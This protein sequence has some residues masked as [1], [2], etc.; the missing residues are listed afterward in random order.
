MPRIALL[1]LTAAMTVP[2][3]AADALDKFW[4]G[5]QTLCGHAY[6][7]ELITEPGGEDGFAGRALVMHVREC[8]PDRIRIPFVVGEDRS[9]TWVLTRVTVDGDPRLELKHD[10][11]DEDGRDDEIT[12]YGGTTTNLGRATQ[13]L[14]PADPHTREIIEPAH[15]NVWRIEVLPG[16]RFSYH[17]RRLGTER[18]FRVDFDLTEPVDPPGPPWGW[19]V[20]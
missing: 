5:L 1:A 8:T 19:Q 4:S 10:H 6:A 11:R 15:A 7:G 13:Q 18:V 3:A 14:F 16:E 20:P 12:K 17:L 2:A 9:R